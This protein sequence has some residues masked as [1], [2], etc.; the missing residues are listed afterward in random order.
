M[1][2]TPAIVL[3]LS[4][5]F[6]FT[7]SLFSQFVKKI[8]LDPNENLNKIVQNERR[9]AQNRMQFKASQN[10]TNYDI[11]YHRL[12]WTV[13]PASD[14]ASIIG[15]VTTYW[16]AVEPMSTIVFDLAGNMNVSQVVQRSTSLAFM[17][18]GGELVITL[19][20]SQ[21]S[22][23]LDSLTITYGGNPV[24]SG[25]GSFE[26]ATHDKIP[27][28]WTLSEP[29]GAMEWWPCKQD[30]ID[31]AD[32]ID[33]IV[34][35]PRF[36]DIH[37]YRTASNGVLIS[38]T[39]NG[40]TMTT[41]WK[42][43]YP[44]PAYLIA[45]AVTNYSV[46]NDM[47]YAGTANEFPITNYVYPE[48]LTEAKN[49][50]P[51]TATILEIY[52]DL[53]EMYP[54]ADEKYG[55]AQFGRGGGMEHTTITFINMGSFFIRS[56]IAHELAHQWFGD[57]ITCGSWEDIWLNEGFAT[58]LEGLSREHIDGNEA[59]TDWK[60]NTVSAITSEN[61]GSVRCTDTTSVNQIFN[62]R[63]S[64]LKGAMLLHMLRYKLG[65]ND[66][67]GAIRNYLSDPKLAFG[68]AR[69]IDLQNHFEAQSGK[70]LDQFFADWYMGEGHPSYQ[71]QW[72]QIGDNAYFLINQEQSHPSVSFFEM[73]LPIKLNG[74]GGE[75]Q[76]IRLENTE[77]GQLIVENVSFPIA[78][79]E[80]DP[81]YELI[82][83]NN[84][85]THS[86]SV[87]VGIDHNIEKGL[88]IYPNPINTLF[89][90]ESTNSDLFNVE[91]T[92]LNSQQILIGEMEGTTHQIDLS[93]FQ[94]GIYL[95]TVRSKDFVTTRKIIKL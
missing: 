64:Y 38:E 36:Y 27:V 6:L 94:K 54:Y 22:G 43:A 69:T 90:I 85:F 59:F 57:K 1:V 21:A 23:V 58:Y 28:L 93:S 7:I 73:P 9:A 84:T 46:Y 16:E 81:E 39:V 74:S 87:G 75:S 45:I 65:D 26:Q 88:R 79:G 44:I 4:F 34:T 77:N 19:P 56:L 8:A 67:Y 20:A 76:W 49:I 31:K 63:L 62:G 60:E 86:P 5:S 83:A 10:T 41:H 53:F 70:D 11:K 13:D 50:T 55:H 51:V 29:Y 25:F 17:H 12:E 14:P 42:H 80:F 92:S 2:R 3:L 78:S 35:H 47:A 33:V 30:L 52:G 18:T 82:S 91:I 15:N 66:F 72:N 40:N 24:S 37:E 48:N 89:T 61:G 71:I 68:Y 32:S 95:I